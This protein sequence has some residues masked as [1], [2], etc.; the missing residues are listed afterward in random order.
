MTLTYPLRDAIF[1][2]ITLSN[3]N[4]CLTEITELIQICITLKLKVKVQFLPGHHKIGLYIKLNCWKFW[5]SG[6]IGIKECLIIILL[7]NVI[8]FSFHDIATE[9]SYKKIKTIR[10][11]KE[12][13]RKAPHKITYIKNIGIFY[14]GLFHT[15]GNIMT[16]LLFIILF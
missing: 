6:S 4:Q 15:V 13:R 3:K 7:S 10:F 11:L 14:I 2:Q 8:F 1:I 12:S 5:N 9:H 16:V